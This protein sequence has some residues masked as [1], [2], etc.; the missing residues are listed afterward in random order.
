MSLAGLHVNALSFWELAQ[1]FQSGGMDAYVKQIQQREK[2]TD[3]DVLTHQKWSGAEYID[4]VLQVIQN[5]SSS[6]TSTTS[7]ESYTESQF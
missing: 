5:G 3:C 7:G 2:E 1:G 6:H 4:S